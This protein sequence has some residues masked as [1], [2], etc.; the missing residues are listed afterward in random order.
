MIHVES[1]SFTSTFKLLDKVSVKHRQIHS[2]VFSKVRPNER[3][4][5]K[6]NLHQLNFQK[7]F[8]V[9][10]DRRSR[11]YSTEIFP[12]FSRIEL[13]LQYFSLSTKKSVISRETSINF[14]DNK[15]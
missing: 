12:V 3:K 4:C 7:M 5:W 1:T 8:V 14:E 6:R 15:V 2:D 13:V 11:D 9:S 10:S